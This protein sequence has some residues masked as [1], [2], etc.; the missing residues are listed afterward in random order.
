MILWSALPLLFFVVYQFCLPAPGAQSGLSELTKDIESEAVAAVRIEPTGVQSDRAILR[1]ALRG[2]ATDS[3]RE[4]APPQEVPGAAGSG[5][6]N[7]S[8]SPSRSGFA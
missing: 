5:T 7:I 2:G 3:T 1:V 4:I 6:A 8:L